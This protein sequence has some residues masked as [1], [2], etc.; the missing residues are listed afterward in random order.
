MTRQENRQCD[1]GADK[2]SASAVSAGQPVSQEISDDAPAEDEEKFFGRA[3]DK[4]NW[5]FCRTGP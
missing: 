2:R 5:N 3:F 4:E 1:R